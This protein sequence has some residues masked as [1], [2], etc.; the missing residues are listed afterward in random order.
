M[1]T[2]QQHKTGHLTGESG[3]YRVGG[4]RYAPD[5]AFISYARAPELQRDGYHPDPPELAVEVISDEGSKQ[6]QTNLRLKLQNY[7]ASGVVVWVVRPSAQTVEVYRPG[8]QAEVVGQDGVLRAE[9]SLPGF[10]LPVA[11]IF[12]W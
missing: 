7:M 2:G 8:Q 4:E 3:G 9:E 1:N 5:V 11:Q 10:E 6:E 12:A